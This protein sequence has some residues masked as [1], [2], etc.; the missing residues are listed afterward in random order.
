MEQWTGA[1]EGSRTPN[2]LLT[3]Q[4]LY[5]LSYT[6]TLGSAESHKP[7]QSVFICYRQT[8]DAEVGFEPTPSEL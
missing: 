6:S 5:H 3:G 2:R 1:N 8:M 7:I 4:L